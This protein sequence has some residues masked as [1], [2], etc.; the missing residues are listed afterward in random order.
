VSTVLQVSR[1]APIP[2]A[3]IVS[4]QRAFSALSVFTPEKHIKAVDYSKSTS[5]ALRYA[6]AL[7]H[8]N[9]RPPHSTC[10]AARAVAA[11]KM[12]PS[13]LPRHLLRRYGPRRGAWRPRQRCRAAALTGDG[14]HD[15][16]GSRASPILFD[17]M[18]IQNTMVSVARPFPVAVATVVA[19]VVLETSVARVVHARDYSCRGLVKRHASVSQEVEIVP[20]IPL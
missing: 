13:L 12:H 11:A 8:L 7:S 17:E 14:S 19:C 15:I 6:A 5:P 1:A 16:A 10:S 4:Q 20:G 18:A 2:T 3:A 9:C